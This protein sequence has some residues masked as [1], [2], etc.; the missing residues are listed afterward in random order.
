MCEEEGLTLAELRVK[1]GYW[2]GHPESLDVSPC[3]QGRSRCL[4]GAVNATEQG[5]WLR[6]S[7][8]CAE[9]YRVRVC[10]GC[11]PCACSPLVV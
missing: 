3:N 11:H 8:Q 9:G 7:T 1:P 4:G 5:R 10:Q 6:Y 2:R